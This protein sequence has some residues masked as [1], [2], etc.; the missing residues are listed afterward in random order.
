M[1]PVCSG[2]LLLS[3]DSTVILCFG[4]CRSHD[5]IF[6]SHTS[7]K[8]CF[9]LAGQVNCCWRPPSQSF[10]V[11]VPQDSWP[12]FLSHDSG[13]HTTT[14]TVLIW[15]Y[16]K[17]AVVC[18]FVFVEA[19]NKPLGSNGCLCDASL[20]PIY[21]P[22]GVSSVPETGVIVSTSTEISDLFCLFSYFQCCIGHKSSEIHAFNIHVYQ[23]T[24]TL[25]YRL[26]STLNTADFSCAWL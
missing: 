24:C 17:P 23:N 6:Q 9:S 2:N 8:Y 5:H 13:S 7:S 11:Q 4:P 3:L 16:C 1:A 15:L 18:T 19:C 20:I 10:L 26:T 12:Y 22:S 21:W 25:H 14:Q